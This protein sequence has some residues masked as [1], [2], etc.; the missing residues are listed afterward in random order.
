MNDTCALP[1]SIDPK[2][3]DALRS[4]WLSAILFG[5]PAGG[6]IFAGVW[7]FRDGAPLLAVVV[8]GAVGVILGLALEFAFLF[9]VRERIFEAGMAAV[10]NVGFIVVG[11]VSTGATIGL[12]ALL[13]SL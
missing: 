7:L 9:V 10:R 11:A 8:A 13:G 4:Y 12:A 5:W 1:T 6:P 2:P 3:E